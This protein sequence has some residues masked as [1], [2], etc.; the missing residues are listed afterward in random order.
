MLRSYIDRVAEVDQ[1]IAAM[2]A[3]TARVGA[4]EEVEIVL[5]AQRRKRGFLGQ[6]VIG[7]VRNLIGL[8]DLSTGVSSF[9]I[10]ALMRDSEKIESLDLLADKLVSRKSVMLLDSRSRDVSSPSAFAAIEEAYREL[11]DDL[12]VAQAAM[13][14]AK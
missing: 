13:P 14:K 9:K 1:D 3:G 11:K 7:H 2:F 5:R 8:E 6:D 4:P 10:D 12:E